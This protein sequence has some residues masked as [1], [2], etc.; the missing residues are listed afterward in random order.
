SLFV[1]LLLLFCTTVSSIK[2]QSI[3]VNGTL[4]CGSAPTPG[5]RVRLWDNDMG[6][7]VDSPKQNSF[8][9]FDG[10]FEF[11]DWTPF[12]DEID[13]IIRIAHD[14]NDGVKPGQRLFKFK[15]PKS[16]IVE[17]KEV[18][19]E[20]YFHLGTINLEFK[21]YNEERY[22]K[23]DIGKRGIIRPYAHKVHRIRRAEPVKEEQPRVGDIVKTVYPEDSSSSEEACSSGLCTFSADRKRRENEKT[24]SGSDEIIKKDED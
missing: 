11:D 8:T 22:Y 13:P 5:I 21:P 19:K 10:N 1:F 17:G 24:T 9:D 23:G 4:L 16:Y 2:F 6:E 7:L 18:P 3:G 20:K 15:I 12:N 14:C